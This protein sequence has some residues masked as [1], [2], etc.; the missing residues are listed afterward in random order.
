MAWTKQVPAWVW[1]ILAAW[2]LPKVVMLGL[3]VTMMGPGRF[4][5]AIGSIALTVL[6]LVLAWYRI[7][8]W[9]RMDAGDRV[10]EKPGP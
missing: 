5:A 10:S 6:F 3:S 2:Q 4:A 8:Y 7:R 9:S 1:L